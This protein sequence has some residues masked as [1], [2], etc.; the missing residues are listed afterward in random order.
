MKWELS[1]QEE[2][3]TVGFNTEAAIPHTEAQTRAKNLNFRI[4]PVPISPIFIG[5]SPLYRTR[6]GNPDRNCCTYIAVRVPF[7]R[8]GVRS[9]S[10][11]SNYSLD[12]SIRS[13][14]LPRVNGTSATKRTPPVLLLVSSLV[15]GDKPNLIHLPSA[16]RAVSFR[17]FLHI[18][19]PHL[20]LPS[21]VAR[22]KMVCQVVIGL[23]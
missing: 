12:I 23:D 13:L 16:V 5:T 17:C 19:Q 21:I 9:E 10:V 15:G 8:C 6:L 22:R 14:A 7:Y 4:L 3:R 2:P 1:P 11:W 18:S 20:T